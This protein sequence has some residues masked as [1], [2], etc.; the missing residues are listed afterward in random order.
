MLTPRA[1]LRDQTFGPSVLALQRDALTQLHFQVTKDTFQYF[2]RIIIIIIIIII[3]IIIIIIIIVTIIIII[4]FFP[5]SPLTGHVIGTGGFK[6]VSSPSRPGGSHRVAIANH[7]Y[8]SVKILLRFAS[9]LI[10]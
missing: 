1:Q 9:G 7:Q 6:V 2:Q 4:T 8:S 5:V 3:V 10:I